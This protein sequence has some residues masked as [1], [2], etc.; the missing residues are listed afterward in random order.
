MINLRTSCKILVIFEIFVILALG[1]GVLAPTENVALTWDDFCEAD[2]SGTFVSREIPLKSGAY[3]VEVCYDVLNPE[4]NKDSINDILGRVDFQTFTCPAAFHAGSISLNSQDSVI[5]QTIWI[6]FGAKISDFK[7]RVTYNENKDFKINSILLS[8]S[9]EYRLVRLLGFLILFAAIDVTIF[10]LSGMTMKSAGRKEE[11]LTLL[12]IFIF[13]S[14]LAMSNVVYYGHDL[15]FHI[16]RIAS[17]ANGLKEGQFPARMH[18]DMLN[19]YGYP[20]SLFYGETLLYI[21]AVLYLL[22][23]PLGTCY[24]IYVLLNNFLTILFSYVC[25]KTITGRKRYALL[26]AFLF[27]LAPYR[28]INIYTRAAVGEYTAMTF[29]PLVILGLWNILTDE[30]ITFCKYLPLCIG[31]SGVVQSHV[32]TTEMVMI[33]TAL[34]CIICYKRVFRVKRLLALGKAAML[35]IL[36]NLWFVIPLLDSMSMDINSKLRTERIQ[37]QGLYPVQWISMFFAGTGMSV[38]NSTQLEIGLPLGASFLFGILIAVYLCK[39][40]KKE[41]Q[42]SID[43]HCMKICLALG[44]LA[45][46]LTS[47]F[48]PWDALAARSVLAEKLLCVIQYPWRYLVIASICFVVV[49][50]LAVKL[51][52]ENSSRTIKGGTIFILVFLNIVSISYYYYDFS[53]NSDSFEILSEESRNIIHIGN[54]EYL[55]TG[56]DVQQLYRRKIDTDENIHVAEL[57]KENGQYVF[58]VKNDSD[59]VKNITVPVLHYDNYRAYDSNTNARLEISTGENNCIAVEIPPGYEGK[60]MVQYHPR[61]IWRICEV[62]SLLTVMALIGYFVLLQKKQCAK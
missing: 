51:L 13:S 5:E 61:I 1:V 32:I 4:N 27:T 30:K 29:L 54:K 31:I 57:E 9:R 50:V 38:K 15:N 36:M 11:L 14:V 7:V 19:G 47:R 62:I 52:E 39:I 28:I 60:V 55:L 23:V 16:N 37:E 3:T 43:F 21:P 41:E 34:T 46:I 58:E 48:F 18:S 44:F 40:R 8:E 12:G 22:K 45:M 49:T 26:G 10:L 35:T 33:F 59:C 56:T 42:N 24:Q 53:Y 17:I 25:L 20:N 6:D 2:T